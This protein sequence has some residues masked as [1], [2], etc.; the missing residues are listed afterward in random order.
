MEWGDILCGIEVTPERWVGG[1]V[2]GALHWFPGAWRVMTGFTG[3][4]VGNPIQ[5]SR[6]ESGVSKGWCRPIFPPPAWGGLS[7]DELWEAVTG[8]R[9]GHWHMGDHPAQVRFIRTDHPW[10][11]INPKTE[12]EG[13]CDCRYLPALILALQNAQVLAARMGVK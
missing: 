13:C 9:L 6:S 12:E 5:T 11:S 8:F 7:D 2:E 3:G 1:V 4:G 10:V